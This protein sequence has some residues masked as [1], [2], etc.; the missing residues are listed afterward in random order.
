M[1]DGVAA[2]EQPN[3]LEWASTLAALALTYGLLFWYL[4]PSL[5]LQPTIT[6]GG[7][8]IAHYVAARYLRDYLL[9]NG[10]LVGWMPGNFAGYPLF[11]FYFPLAFL[12]IAGLSLVASFPV[13]FK[14]GTL[15]G[16]FDCRSRRWSRSAGSAARFPYRPSALS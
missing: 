3:R 7:D 15:A 8:T 12:L 13:A 2:D 6:A 14:L 1:S 9:P 5:L 11:L 10:K 4:K 16:T